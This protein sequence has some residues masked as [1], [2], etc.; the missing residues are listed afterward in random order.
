M[1]EA[2]AAVLN[3]TGRA[4]EP[5]LVDRLVRHDQELLYANTRVH[6]DTVRS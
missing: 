5:G 2:F 4:H 6:D 1:A 3:E